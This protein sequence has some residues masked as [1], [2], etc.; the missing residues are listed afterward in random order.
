MDLGK[1]F[2]AAAPLDADDVPQVLVSRRHRGI[3]SE[4]AAEI[5]L[6]FGL[7]LQLVDGDPAHSALRDVPH[8]HAGIERREQMF[9]RIGECVAAAEFGWLVD[10]DRKAARNRL[11]ADSERF[12]LRSAMRLS[13][14][15][16][17]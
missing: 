12:D 4:E 14:P 11:P 5:D 9:L 13:L 7:D 1:L 6:A 16:R 17:R 2:F 3:N 15:G 10:V 8:R